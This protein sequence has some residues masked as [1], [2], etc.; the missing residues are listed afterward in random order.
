ML[1]VTILYEHIPQD[2]YFITKCLPVSFDVV[3]L[4]TNVPLN[5][6]IHIIADKIYE[7]KEKP[8]FEKE[9]FIKLMEMATSGIFMY[10]DKYFKQTDGVTMGSPLGPTMANFCLSH[11]ENQL[12]EECD[13]TNGPSLYARY[14]DDIFCVFRS[15]I[16]HE[17]F[18]NKLN[19]LHPNLK[20]TMELGNSS[21]AFLDTFI[22]LPTDDNGTFSSQ[23]F[24]KATHTGLI[25]NF[26]SICPHK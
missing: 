11:F 24:R 17:S 8:K 4:F 26:E 12:L 20:F 16:S 21:L 23:V 25:L 1:W 7:T 18:L 3:S 2:L 10:G 13:D 9:V 22:S 15:G 5:E 14:V 19:S 6:T